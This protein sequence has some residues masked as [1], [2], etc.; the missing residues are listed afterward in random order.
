ALSIMAALEVRSEHPLGEA[1]VEEA[2]ERGLRIP[3]AR[4]FEVVAGKGVRGT[5]GAT[6]Y[7]V[8]RPEWIAEL[9]LTFPEALREK[10]AAA[11]ERGESVIALLDDHS[12]LAVVALADRVRQSAKDTISA[13]K[14]AGVE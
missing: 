5:V 1:V 13:L 7:N 14:E 6:T 10:L 9:G 8:G 12:A 3:D 2:G 4:D 11:E